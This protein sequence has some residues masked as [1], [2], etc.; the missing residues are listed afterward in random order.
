MKE[1]RASSDY[2]GGTKDSSK[3]TGKPLFTAGNDDSVVFGG[4]VMAWRPVDPPLCLQMVTCSETALSLWR[5]PSVRFSILI[6]TD[7]LD[8]ILVAMNKGVDAFA[9]FGQ[10]SLLHHFTAFVIPA[11][12]TAIIVLGQEVFVSASSLARVSGVRLIPMKSKNR[13]L[14][15]ISSNKGSCKPRAKGD[16]IGAQN[17]IAKLA[18]RTRIF[19]AGV[20]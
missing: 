11:L 12:W 18:E 4:F 17:R 5:L 9:R 10:V 16:V 1:G 3:W 6:F 7:V 15:T 14:I 13:G 2:G 20:S 8:V 19:L